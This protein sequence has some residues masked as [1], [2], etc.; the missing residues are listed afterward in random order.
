MDNQVPSSFI[1]MA[2][3]VQHFNYAGLNIPYM[4]LEF[5]IIPFFCYAY[6]MVY[7]MMKERL[8]YVPI[9]QF[10]LS[11]IFIWSVLFSAGWL[12]SL[13]LVYSLK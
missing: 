13:L 1:E 10:L 2:I 11:G 8:G 3:I 6:Y 7:C 4:L 12:C 9:C 5:W